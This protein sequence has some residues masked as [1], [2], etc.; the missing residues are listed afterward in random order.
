MFNQLLHRYDRFGIRLQR[1]LCLLS[2]GLGCAIITTLPASGL[3]ITVEYEKAVDDLWVGV[4]LPLSGDNASFGQ[5]IL[6]GMRSALSPL[7]K[8]KLTQAGYHY[9][10][11]HKIKLIVRDHGGDIEQGKLLVDELY[12]EHRAAV[13]VGGLSTLESASYADISSRRAK[14]F[15]SLIPKTLPNLKQHSRAISFA[16]SY[17]WQLKVIAQHLKSTSSAPPMLVISDSMSRMKG[18]RAHHMI[19]DFFISAGATSTSAP[20]DLN[21]FTDHIMSVA[22]STFKLQPK[23]PELSP[24]PNAAM[25]AMAASIHN[26]Q[27]QVLVMMLGLKESKQLLHELHQLSFKGR[28]YGLDY[29]DHPSFSAPQLDLDIHYVIQYD[30]SFFSEDFKDIYYAQTQ[31]EPTVLAALGYDVTYFLL[32]LYQQTKSTRIPPFLQLIER[33]QLIRAPASFAGIYRRSEHHY[34]QRPMVLRSLHSSSHRIIGDMN[35]QVDPIM[36]PHHLDP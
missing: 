1:I 17:A 29:W 13:V 19:T 5:Q 14:I 22:D 7:S 3:L 20:P 34:I 23:D 35:A 9:P 12:T 15:I 24:E 6:S 32:Q 11:F 36:T 16:S 28:I 30:Q 4:V 25:Q 26:T 2:T 27:T 21:D 10:L 18:T 8:A 31:T 33:N